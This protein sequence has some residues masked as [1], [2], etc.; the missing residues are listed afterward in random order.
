MGCAGESSS[1]VISGG[2]VK[3]SKADD[4][5]KAAESPTTTTK[6]AATGYN[7][8]MKMYYSMPSSNVDP[9]AELTESERAKIIAKQSEETLSARE[10]LEQQLAAR[11]VNI[12]LD[13]HEK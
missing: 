4:D 13:V 11:G 1:C 5:D 8:D 6:A 2:G 3:L 10:R 9:L 7:E 12:D